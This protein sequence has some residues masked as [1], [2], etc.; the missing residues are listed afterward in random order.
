MYLKYYNKL[1]EK[2]K[3]VLELGITK[4]KTKKLM[5]KN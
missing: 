1:K 3:N 4:N 5:L 2:R